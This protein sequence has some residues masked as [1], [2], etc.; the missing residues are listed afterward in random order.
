MSQ[1]AEPTGKKQGRGRQFQPGQSGNPKGRPPGSRNKLCGDLLAA[2]QKDFDVNGEK[3][4][5]A[6]RKA[7]PAR[8]IE[9]LVSLVPKEFDLGEKTAA[10]LAEFC[11]LAAEG[12]LP[13][14]PNPHKD[15]AK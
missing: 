13:R 2:L 11:M 7:S 14:S 6:M 15:D 5:I 9:A 12:R 10:S 3:A 4:V 1:A 8:Y